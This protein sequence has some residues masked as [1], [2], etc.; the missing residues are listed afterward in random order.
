MKN[1]LVVIGSVLFLAG[2]NAGNNQTNIEIIQNMMDQISVKSQD[3]DPKNPDQVQMLTPPANTISRE[4]APYKYADNMEA[5][6]KQENPYAADM[7]AEFLT[8]GSQQYAIYCTICH[9]ATG[10]GDGPVTEHKDMKGRPRNLINAD[11]KAYSDGRMYHAITMGYGIMG[12]YASQ[13]TDAKKR[14]AVVNYVRSLQ[15][16][17]Q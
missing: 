3:W 14:W 10:A 12:G 16:Q 7:S 9:G 5:A 8:L 4:K 13:I 6:W 2:C 17:A 15:K 11:A 1:A